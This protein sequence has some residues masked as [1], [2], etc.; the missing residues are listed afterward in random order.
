MKRDFRI[1]VDRY[2]PES[3][4]GIDDADNEVNRRLRTNGA[5]VVARVAV[6][7]P[8][9]GLGQSDLC[10]DRRGGMAP[11][12][13]KHVHAYA[14]VGISL[15]RGIRFYIENGV[16]AKTDIAPALSC[17]GSPFPGHDPLEAPR[18][19]QAP[20]LLASAVSGAKDI[21]KRVRMLIEHIEGSGNNSLL[22]QESLDSLA[23]VATDVRCSIQDAIGEKR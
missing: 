20:E 5:A 12:G 15:S 7:Q 1:K 3:H 17:L 10:G 18:S 11:S 9:D 14:F 21:E 2:Y 4:Y 8:L 23:D 19:K 6:E 13:A 16:G 22:V